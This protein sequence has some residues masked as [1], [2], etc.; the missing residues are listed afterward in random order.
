MGDGLAGVIKSWAKDPEFRWSLIE[1]AWRS[2]AGDTVGERAS[3]ESFD[4]GTLTVRVTDP[5]WIPTLRELETD[6]VIAMRRRPGGDMVTH[7][8]WVSSEP[9]S[10][11][12]E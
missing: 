3:A 6:L 12:R 11:G 9:E 4:S 5:S 2:A 8:N 7:I 10:T 1:R